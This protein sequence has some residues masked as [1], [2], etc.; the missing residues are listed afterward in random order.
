MDLN[1]SY[2][3]DRVGGIHALEEL[4]DKFLKS[5]YQKKITF[6][7]RVLDETIGEG[8]VELVADAFW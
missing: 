2:T 5:E 8:N 7:G 4:A 3:M 1:K 6:K